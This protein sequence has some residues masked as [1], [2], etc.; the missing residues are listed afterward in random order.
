MKEFGM[1]KKLR[2]FLYKQRVAT[3]KEKVVWVKARAIE[4]T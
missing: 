1:S 3:W 4:R 2:E